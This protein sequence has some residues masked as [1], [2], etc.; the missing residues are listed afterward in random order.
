MRILEELARLRTFVLAAVAVVGLGALAVVLEA[1]QRNGHLDPGLPA[2]LLGIVGLLWLALFVTHIVALYRRLDL[3]ESRD[4]SQPPVRPAP[5]LY[6]QG[7]ELLSLAFE[8]VG[9]LEFRWPWQDWR[10]AWVF[11]NSSKRVD[12]SVGVAMPVCFTSHWT[13]GS[14]LVT[15]TS[16]RDRTMDLPGVR[17]VWASGAPGAVFAR[18]VQQLGELEHSHGEALQTWSM[19]DVLAHGTSELPYLRR[20]MRAAW[21]NPAPIVF[22]AIM[23]LLFLVMIVTDLSVV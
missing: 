21:L 17:L 13:D 9:Q 20:T 5:G 10:L 12:S 11:T 19:A 8:P 7:Q 2:F 18:H 15:T 1:P 6:A 22:V 3:Y 23:A 4:A 14:I 16:R